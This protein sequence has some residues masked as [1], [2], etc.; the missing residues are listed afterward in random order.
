MNQE[1]SSGDIL[2]ALGIPI[3]GSR[4]K[5]GRYSF[6]EVKWPCATFWVTAKRNEDVIAVQFSKIG[7]AEEA[8]RYAPAFKAAGINP[9]RVVQNRATYEIVVP[10][11]PDHSM[12]LVALLEAKEKFERLMN[13]TPPVS[14]TDSGDGSKLPS[15]F[16]TATSYQPSNFATRAR[17]KLPFFVE[18]EL[19]SRN[20]M[21]SDRETV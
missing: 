4:G 14:S 5:D 18:L 1:Y 12:N 20:D 3:A 10:K 7:W 15:A 9:R 16:P 6:S 13:S 17:A 2:I 11:N 21:A 8:R 19:P